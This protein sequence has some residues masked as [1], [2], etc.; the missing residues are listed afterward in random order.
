VPAIEVAAV[1]DNCI[2]RY[3]DPLRRSFVGG[4]AVNVAVQLAA[5]RRS[6]AYFGAIGDDAD[7]RRIVSVLAERGVNVDHVQIRRGVT[8]YTDIAFGPA[9]DRIFAFEEFGVCRGYAPNAEEVRV[10]KTLRHVH[11]GWL[12]DGGRLKRT[13]LAAGVGVSQDL[14]VNAAAVDVSPDGLSIAFMSAVTRDEAYALARRALASGAGLA[15]VTMGALG[16]MASDGSSVVRMDAE[17]VEPVDT[18]G[19]GDSFIAAFIDS[20]LQGLDLRDSLA[21]AG[22]AATITCM[23][24]GGFPQDGEPLAAP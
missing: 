17:P 2:D 6:V 10:L 23:H 19:A 24:H 22:A 11:I 7:G 5:R 20:R 16:S 13:L 18:T 21:A 9:G 8:A 12:D 4:N 14:S 1:G 3:G 15:V